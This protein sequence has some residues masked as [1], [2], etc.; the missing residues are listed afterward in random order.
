L[1]LFILSS[2]IML[3]AFLNSDCSLSSPLASSVYFGTVLDLRFILTIAPAI[4]YGLSTKLVWLDLWLLPLLRLP[5][6][7]NFNSWL[8]MYLVWSLSSLLLS[9][10]CRP[11]FISAYPEMTA[12][13]S[14]ARSLSHVSSLVS[15]IAEETVSYRSLPLAASHN[16]KAMTFSAL[17]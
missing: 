12:S 7:W 6:G 3:L 1:L 9:L 15:R 2:G 14:L 13:W 8:A 5:P 10:G 17:Y 4:L 16:T 11:E